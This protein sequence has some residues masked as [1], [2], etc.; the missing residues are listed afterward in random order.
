[1]TYYYGS[2][3]KTGDQNAVGL[4]NAAEYQ[5]NGLYWTVR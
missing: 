5:T 1:M 2:H 4:N 3:K